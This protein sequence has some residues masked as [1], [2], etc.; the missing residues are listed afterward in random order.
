M[1]FY[2]NLFASFYRM[3]TA[4][5]ENVFAPFKFCIMWCQVFLFIMLAKLFTSIYNIDLKNYRYIVILIVITWC[6]LISNYYTRS[7]AIDI[8]YEYNKK[9]KK[10]Q[11]I[12]TIVACFSFC[13][14]IIVF[15]INGLIVNKKG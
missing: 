15:L 8:I 11:N 13:L 9:S 5:S 6:G 4:A 3:H 12:W 10:E 1:K 14:P 7:K 2:N